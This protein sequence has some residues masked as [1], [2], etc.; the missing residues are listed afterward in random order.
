MS[1]LDDKVAGFM[2]S[3]AKAAQYANGDDQTDVQT[4]GGPIPSLAKQARQNLEEI[5]RYQPELSDIQT[6]LLSKADQSTLDGL[7]DTSGGIPGV[8]ANNASVLFVAD[9]IG[10]GVGATYPQAW[11]Y[12]SAMSIMNKVA[13]DGYGY[14]TTVN[15]ANALTEAG[16]TS[17]GAIVAEGAVANRLALNPGQ[18]LTLTGR[19][20]GN[21][22][23]F[24]DA[25]TSVGSS[26]EYRLNGVLYN[27]K[28]L[29]SA[30]QTGIMSTFYTP[31]QDGGPLCKS[32]DIIEVKAIN[33]R[34]TITGI[35]SARTTPNSPIVYVAAKSGYTYQDFTTAA[36]MDEFAWYLNFYRAA[37]EK[38]MVVGLGT[39]S[40]YQAG[41]RADTPADMVTKMAAF[42]AG[43]RARCTPL[44]VAVWVPPKS[45]P[46]IFPIIKP[47]YTY[48]DYVKAIVAFGAQ[49]NVAVIRVDRTVLGNAN[50][51]LFDGVHPLPIGNMVL[52]QAT[53]STLGVSLNTRAPT[54]TDLLVEGA[55]NRFL[56]AA[57]QQA[58]SAYD[59]N[60]GISGKPAAGDKAMFVKAGR[61]FFLDPN[62]ANWYASATTAPTADCFYSLQKNNVEIARFNF[63]ANKSTCDTI[64]ITGGG[65]LDNQFEKFV[66]LK[67]VAPAVADAAMADVVF[68][69]PAYL[70]A[71]Q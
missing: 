32:T 46:T 40:I 31:F 41:A 57:R 55:N 23:L 49:N 24:F 51:M 14:F 44:R 26:L 35:M 9:S 65:A 69:I 45:D 28:A 3:M 67:L 21:V 33:A 2:D 13:P 17:T 71:T 42:I 29:S 18:T 11:A 70:N 4:P 47:G 61:R 43:M 20:I 59:F 56:T 19:A 12:S 6:V 53:C 1:L 66:S 7:G 64:T 36:A 68:F 25:A 52:A 60:Q 58:L 50:V 5:A 48:N 54:T 16:I 38:V 62:T 37:A 8:I 22:D 30:G 15:M 10:E 27:T 39:N 34:A 63:V